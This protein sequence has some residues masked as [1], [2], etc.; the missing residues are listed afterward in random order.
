MFIVNSVDGISIKLP[1]NPEIGKNYTIIND[2]AGNLTVLP[3]GSQ[4]ISGATG[5][6]INTKY[7]SLNLVYGSSNNWY[8]IN[9]FS[10]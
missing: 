8:I 4:Y 10:I 1:N 3:N 9:K 6:E 2:V 7:D 5:I